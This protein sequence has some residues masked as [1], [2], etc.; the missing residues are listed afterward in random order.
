MPLQDARIG[1]RLA[2]KMAGVGHHE[3]RRKGVRSVKDKVV[4]PHDRQRFGRRQPLGIGANRHIRVDGPERHRGGVDLERPDIGRRMCHLSV[5]I[6][7]FNDIGIHD[8]Q[9]ANAR[10]GQIK[11]DGA[12]E[13]ADTDKQ[14]LA[15]QQ[16]RLSPSPHFRENDLP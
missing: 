15:R 2:R 6:A 7:Q 12:S 16:T 9:V 1:I 5:E 14:H 8:P 10:C 3:L 13:T 11:A 4:V